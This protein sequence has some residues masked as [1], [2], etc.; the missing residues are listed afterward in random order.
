MSHLGNL[1]IVMISVYEIGTVNIVNDN[2]CTE[3]QTYSAGIPDTASQTITGEAVH[4]VCT[5]TAIQTRHI[6]TSINVMITQSIVITV[7]TGTHVA[8]YLI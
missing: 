2:D 3:L 7:M 1:G 5:C 8:V 4:A 6:M